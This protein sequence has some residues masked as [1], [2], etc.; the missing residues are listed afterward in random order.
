MQLQDNLLRTNEF[1]LLG[2]WLSFVPPWA[3]SPAELAQLNY[4]ARSILTTWGDRRA[5][6]AGLHEY[7]NRDYAGLTADYYAPRW[8][9][10]FDSLLASLDTHTA[11][12]QID[13]YAFGDAFN[14]QTKPYTAVPLGPSYPA[15]LAIANDL[16]LAPPQPSSH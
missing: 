6:E 3:T 11:P 7:A 12:K 10:Y 15:A 5:S 13:W 4:D 1:F 2:H 8:K 16:H 14:R 9:L